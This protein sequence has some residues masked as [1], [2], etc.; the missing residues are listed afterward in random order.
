MQYFPY[1]WMMYD[2]LLCHLVHITYHIPEGI[3]GKNQLEKEAISGVQEF[4]KIVKNNID[5]GF[6]GVYHN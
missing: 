2:H 3:E 5:Y 6:L 1:Y 4:S